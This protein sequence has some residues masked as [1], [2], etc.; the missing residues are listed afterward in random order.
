MDRAR[1]EFERAGANLV[2]I[3]QLTPRHAAHFRRRQHIELPVLTD[4]ERRTYRAAGA[5]V[6]NLA[7]L[8]GP[9]VVAKGALTTLRT[10]KL[11]G[12]TIGHPAQLGGAMVIAPPGEIVWSRMAKDASDN[13]SP[14]EILTALRA[15]A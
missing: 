1:D 14:K 3:G 15:A 4:Q 8:V 12:R 6:G 2:L 5:K 11:Q 7:D 13:A 10:R 9:K